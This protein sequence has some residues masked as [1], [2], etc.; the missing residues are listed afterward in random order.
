MEKLLRYTIRDHQKIAI[1]DWLKEKPQHLQA[2]AMRWYQEI[3]A[4]GPEVE[5]IFHDDHPIGCVEDAP[6]AELQVYSAH[7]NL[8]FYYGAFFYDE[9]Q[10]LQGT[11]KRMRH[12]K[13][14]PE[15]SPDEKTI[16]TFLKTAYLDIQK[17]LREV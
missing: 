12:I 9:K 5:M 4:I 11:G 3:E 6:F 1:D 15:S 14:K 10:W 8:G 13:I 16:R 7:I 2:E 17:R